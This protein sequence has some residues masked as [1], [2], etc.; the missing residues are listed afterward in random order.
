M[1]ST[2]IS[3]ILRAVLLVIATTGYHSGSTTP[4]SKVTDKDRRLNEE[5]GSIRSDESNGNAF[6]EKMI[7]GDIVHDEP[8][9][10]LS[11]LAPTKKYAQVRIYPL[12]AM[13]FC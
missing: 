1:E 12:K 5:Q 8:N 6:G 10:I 7:A 4:A 11:V 9:S 3:S 13:V 2:A